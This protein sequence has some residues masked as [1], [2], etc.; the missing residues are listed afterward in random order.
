MNANS[1]NYT[2]LVFQYGNTFSNFNNA[3]NLIWP[4]TFW[5]VETLVDFP[6]WISKFS[7]MFLLPAFS[8]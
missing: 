2:I 1:W 4:F 8:P 6:G 3:Y 5:L 7:A